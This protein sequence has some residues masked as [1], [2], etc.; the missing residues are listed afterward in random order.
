MAVRCLLS[1]THRAR[2]PA[3]VAVLCVIG[4][5]ATL[6]TCVTSAYPFVDVSDPLHFAIKITTTIVLTNVMGYAFYRVRV[7]ARESRLR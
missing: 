1:W 4:F 3:W 5:C 6:F 7:L 2:I